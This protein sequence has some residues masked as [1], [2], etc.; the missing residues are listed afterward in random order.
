MLK[1]KNLKMKMQ[2]TKMLK[3]KKMKNKRNIRKMKTSLKMK[4][5]K[6]MRKATHWQVKAVSLTP[7]TIDCKILVFSSD[8]FLRGQKL[9]CS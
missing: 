6:L 4:K 8:S 1:M 2:K 7:L 5:P 3:T 9:F